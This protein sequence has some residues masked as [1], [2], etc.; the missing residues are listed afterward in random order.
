MMDEELGG[1]S[2]GGC[3]SVLKLWR[4]S[5]V[6]MA[7]TLTMVAATNCGVTFVCSTCS[8]GPACRTSVWQHEC[9]DGMSIDPHRLTIC[10][11][12]SRSAALISAPATR[13]A[14]SGQP[15]VRPS[16]RRATSWRSCFTASSLPQ[17]TL[18]LWAFQEMRT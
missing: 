14:M 13:Q 10:L 4:D 9:D 7:G 16:T 12:H 11:Q 1:D 15:S 18:L 5:I 2:G 17:P 8:I 3:R 6:A